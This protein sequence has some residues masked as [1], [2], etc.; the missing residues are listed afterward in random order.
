MVCST[1]EDCVYT[2]R[3]VNATT[4]VTVLRS[5]FY[6]TTQWESGKV[7]KWEKRNKEK[8]K[9]RK[10]YNT[11]TPPDAFV[12]FVLPVLHRYFVDDIQFSHFFSIKINVLA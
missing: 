9:K 5:F 10:K 2:R 11:N 4:G 7:G 1:N 8:K 3:F 6:Y 12:C